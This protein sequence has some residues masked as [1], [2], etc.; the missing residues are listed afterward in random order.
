VSVTGGFKRAVIEPDASWPRWFLANMGQG[1]ALLVRPP[2]VKAVPI[3]RAYARLAVGALVSV[4]VV[5]AAMIWLDAPTIT[6][7]KDLP[8][9]LVDVFEELTDF[10]R[11]GWFLTPF[12]LLLLAMAALASPSLPRFTQRVLAI[13]AVRFEFLFLAIA[14]PGLFV[15]IVKRLIG[16]ARPYVGGHVD[17]FLYAPFGWRPEYASLPSGHSTNVFAVLIAM[18]ILWPRLR[19]ILWLYA[20]IIAVSR[21]VVLAHNPSDVVAGAIVGAVG[22]LLVRDWFAAR[23]LGFT[24]DVEGRVHALP[25][26]SFGRIKRVA[27]QLVARQLVAS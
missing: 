9:W 18:G 20:L 22:A 21:V 25:G 1:L 24:I 23:R 13:I 7:A 17:P 12:G 16:R 14:V 2:R 5:A 15:T 6:A 8:R 26:P 11:S 4:V 10:G 3:W 19:P 27:R